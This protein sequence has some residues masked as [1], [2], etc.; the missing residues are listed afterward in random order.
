MHKYS[1]KHL[2][3]KAARM[4]SGIETKEEAEK[5]Y[6]ENMERAKEGRKTYVQT[7]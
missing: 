5:V 6:M 1:P 2:R 3:M 7:A 4:K